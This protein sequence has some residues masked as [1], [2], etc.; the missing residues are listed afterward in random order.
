MREQ[1]VT[2]IGPDLPGV[3]ERRR[4]E[5]PVAARFVARLHDDL[6]PVAT[7][8]GVIA[9]QLAD[10]VE[11]ARQHVDRVAPRIRKDLAHV[12][13]LHRH[14][15]RQRRRRIEQRHLPILFNARRP[16]VSPAFRSAAFRNRG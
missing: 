15:G 8:A 6:L 5:G 3:A 7:D 10:L 4:D 11:A 9:G 13:V 12:R 14:P 2:A 16:A 1:W